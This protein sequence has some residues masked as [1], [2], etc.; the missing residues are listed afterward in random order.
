M[1]DNKGF[2]HKPKGSSEGGQFTGNY[3]NA[4]EKL[5]NE[6]KNWKEQYN[7]T[8][9]KELEEL[10]KINLDGKFVKSGEYSITQPE[11]NKGVYR[12]SDK[13]P[14]TTSTYSFIKN[15]NN[16]VVEIN[17]D[18]DIQK[19]FDK[20]TP[21]ERVEIAYRYIMDNLRGVYSTTDGQEILLEK[22][23]ADKM[24]HTLN[25]IKIRLTPELSS[26]I[27]SAK[28]NGITKVEHKKFKLFAYYTTF[29]RI[30]SDTYKGIL[31]VGIRENQRG[32]LYDIN[33]FSKI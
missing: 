25:E 21:K 27:K 32:T 31:N 28:F 9:T 22:V 11:N 12:G 23:G 8:S 1:I 30:G 10:L 4:G 24:T 13:Y 17:L 33:P 18:S 5:H 16:G 6:V 3:S 29:F 15:T 7:K 14:Q 19:Q 20:A 2:E 26:L